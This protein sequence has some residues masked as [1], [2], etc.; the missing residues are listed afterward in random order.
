MVF[1]SVLAPNFVKEPFLIGQE[2]K[3]VVGCLNVVC[4]LMLIPVPQDGLPWM[5][6]PPGSQGISCEPS[7]M[8]TGQ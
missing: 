2:R 3:N 7:P 8:V 4:I 1:P 5:S 6:R